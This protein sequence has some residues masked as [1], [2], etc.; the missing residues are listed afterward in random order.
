MIFSYTCKYLFLFR[1]CVQNDNEFIGQCNFN[2][3]CLK[4][5]VNI[6]K[7]IEYFYEFGLHLGTQKLNKCKFNDYKCNIFL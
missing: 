3:V 7:P 6:L 2:N 4:Y 1:N 5:K